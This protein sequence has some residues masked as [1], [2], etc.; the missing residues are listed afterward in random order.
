MIR[1]LFVRTLLH[2]A[3]EFAENRALTLE[4]A[5]EIEISCYNAAVRTSI[6]SEEPPR[7]QWDSPLFVDVYSTRCGTIAVFLDPGSA[8]CR[9][10]G[11]T[12]ARRLLAAA[13]VDGLPPI[14]PDEVGNLSEK[15]LCPRATEAERAEIKKR[16][17]QKVVVKESNLFR[18]PH[19]GHA[20]ARTSRCSG[21][22]STRPPTTS[23]SA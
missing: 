10:Y 23:A 1:R 21:G 13:P 15:E 4:T 6:S 20:A 5:R 2:A 19:C 17:E 14:R 16:S 11:A 9:A 7:R 3:P 12:L 22:A 8:P 18:C